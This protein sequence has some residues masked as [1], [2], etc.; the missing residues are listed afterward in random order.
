MMKS[1]F[2]VMT[3]VLLAALLLF[4]SCASPAVDADGSGTP[5]ATQASLP[6]ATD[7]Q[8]EPP[9]TDDP[10]WS[11]DL[12]PVNYNG[13]KIRMLVE[14]Q[15]FAAD[16]FAAAEINGN[17]VNDAVYTR[18]SRIENELGVKFEVT[19]ASSSSVYDVGDR[20][21]A[22][23]SS[24]DD[25]FDLITMPGY[26][27]T[28]YALAGCFVN[29]HDIENL[30]LT[31]KY[32]TQGFNEIMDN[33]RMQFVASGAY[34]ISMIRN[35]Y[36]T[37]YNKT[38]MNSRKL[39]DPYEL[40]MSGE[41]TVEKQMELIKDVYEDS[42]NGV[43]DKE[44]FYG[45]VS[46]TNTSVDPYW[47]GFNMPLLSVDKGTG[48]YSIDIDKDKM[49][50]ILTAIRDLIV[51]NPATFNKGSSGGDVDG[52]YST[53]A[54]EMFGNGRCLMTTSMIF[55]IEKTLTASGFSDEYGIVPIP[56]Y[57]RDQAEYRTHTQ[58]Q[59]SLMAVPS[60]VDTATLPMI[61][62][63]MQCISYRSYNDVFPA[64]YETAL[65][66]RYLQNKE[67]VDMLNLIYGSIKIEGC[68]IYSSVFAILGQLRSMA[69]SA[70]SLSSIVSGTRTWPKKC[71]N[72]NEG[73][74]KLE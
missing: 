30:D 15:E 18:N 47:V 58:D 59:L 17:A 40:T 11:Y 10:A 73:L 68:F 44:D 51:N 27:H 72:L 37:I 63:V 6:V 57:D 3:A 64:Y 36:I 24:G 35:M 69:S 48:V 53:T 9:V 71:D 49:I 56:K 13:T 55:N 66:Y 19:V 21:K 1:K 39:A 43:R 46:G 74:A 7:E 65:S 14:G 31:K 70:A 60:T 28:S 8:T 2:I 67:S 52:A 42:G 61:G 12:A 45:F 41:W 38:E 33:G 25:V 50:G 20:I 22:L 4:A 34:S 54:I 26:T 16:E 62:T 29:M 32:W 23:C 5:E